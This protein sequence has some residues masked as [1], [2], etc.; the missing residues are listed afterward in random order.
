LTLSLSGNPFLMLCET[1]FGVGVGPWGAMEQ[2]M[3]LRFIARGIGHRPATILGVKHRNAFYT[4][5]RCHRDSVR[6]DQVWVPA[7]GSSSG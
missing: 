7:T 6:F 1:H 5:C 4:F 3:Q 2:W